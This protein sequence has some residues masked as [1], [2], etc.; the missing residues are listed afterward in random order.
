[1][2][3]ESSA[4]SQDNRELVLVILLLCWESVFVCSSF[5][6]TGPLTYLIETSRIH[7]GQKSQNEGHLDCR[8]LS[9]Y[10]PL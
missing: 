2:D 3:H 10:K 6:S 7:L 8:G 4:W 9:R 1:M 5:A